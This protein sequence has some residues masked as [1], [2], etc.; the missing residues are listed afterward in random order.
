[1]VKR[2]LQWKAQACAP[3]RP[4][5][6]AYKC[7]IIK[8]LFE[9]GLKNKT[10]IIDFVAHNQ[11]HSGKWV[12]SPFQR[13]EVFCFLFVVERNSLYISFDCWFSLH[14][15]SSAVSFSFECNDIQTLSIRLLNSF[16]K[17][18]TA[19]TTPTTTIKCKMHA[20]FATKTTALHT[21]KC[22]PTAA[23]NQQ[24]ASQH[25]AHKGVYWTWPPVHIQNES[26]Y[27]LCV[28]A[29][30]CSSLF[31]SSFDRSI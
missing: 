29:A 23:S 22:E 1:M 31:I 20:C 9:T 15:S 2:D 12:W 28:F 30:I 7:T 18:S 26:N 24:S 17:R 6:Q 13:F 11:N 16:V 3:V 27:G 8:M 10:K 4:S 25:S 5:V 19:T 14:V 21:S